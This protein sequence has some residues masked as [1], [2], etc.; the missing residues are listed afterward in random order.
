MQHKFVLDYIILHYLINSEKKTRG[1]PCLTII[2]VTKLRDAF[3]NFTNEP[4]YEPHFEV[5][6]QYT[7]TVS[8]T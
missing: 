5:Y 7:L 6:V 2:D 3:R 4:K 1:V 8:L